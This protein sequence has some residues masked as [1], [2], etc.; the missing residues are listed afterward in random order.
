M[1]PKE[2][3]SRIFLDGGDP[4]ETREI[5]DLLG[6]LDGQT[7]NPTLISKNPE[8][9]RRL[10]RG[11]RFSEDEILGFY[12]AVVEEISGMLPGG[13]ISVEVYADPQTAAEQMLPQGKMM[14]GWIPNAHI[15]FPSSDQGFRAAE[16]AVKEGLRVNMTLCF[17]QEQ[18]A[19]AYAATRGAKKGDVF[20]SPFVGRL[21]DW[22]ENGMSLIENIIRMYR[23]GD[24]HVEV[25]TA[26]V[27]HLDHLLY[28]IKLGSDIITVP[29]GILREW[30]EKGLPMPG[31][32]YTYNAGS[33]API[34]YRD[35]DLAKNWQDFD[36]SH[37]LTT[38]GMEKFSADW[39]S[40]IR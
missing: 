10:E 23:E 35:P 8:A 12:R 38:K 3:T 34:P 5:M 39:K 21:D 4:Q 33:L 37:E 17:R 26:S 13:S 40:L 30:G 19:A 27:R 36:L 18:A 29:A 22:G 6:F 28:A 11:E 24:G 31:R 14:N 7:T 16:K 9:R 2:L 32:D 25:L 15:K 20:V 1:R